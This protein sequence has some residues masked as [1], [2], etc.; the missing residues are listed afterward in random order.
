MRNVI[1]SS[2]T[3]TAQKPTVSVDHIDNYYIVEATGTQPAVAD[4]RWQYVAPGGA[5]PMPT[6]AAPYLWHKTVTVLTDGSTLDPVVEFAGSMGQNGIDYDLVP[7]HSSILKGEDNSLTPENVTCALVKRN[8]DGSA[9]NQTTVPT[10][11]SIK[12]T[13]DTTTTTYTLGAIV[14]TSGVSLIVFS[15]YYGTV[16]IERHTISVVAEGGQGVDGRGI[17]SQDYRFKAES[18]GTQP[19]APTTDAQWNTWSALNAAGYSESVP[20]LWR[21]CK[22]VYVDGHGNTETVYVV[23]GP[24]VWGHNGEDIFYLDLDNEMDSI[25][26]DSTGTTLVQVV[27]TTNY[28]L[29]KG[30]GN[31]TSQSTAPTAAN[32]RLAGITPTVTPGS[33]Y[34]RLQWTIP[35]NTT[36]SA[37]KYAVTV[38]VS[39]DGS[40]YRAVFTANV[41]KSGEPGVSPAIYQLLLSATEASFARDGSNVLTPTQVQV[42]CGYT[43]SVG[44]TI[45]K[46]VGDS[47]SD[48]MSIDSKYNIFYRPI[49]ANGKAG[50]WAWMKDL[51]STNFYLN[52]PSSTRN[53]AYEFVLSSSGIYTLVADS[54]IVDRETLPINKDGLNGTQGESAFVI[55][56][57]NDTDAF[58][59]DCDGKISASIVRETTATMYYGVTPLDLT[60]LSYT[61]KYEDGTTC[62]SEVAVATD[63]STGKVTV[64]LGST[65]YA[66]TKTIFIDITGSCS[67]GSKTIRFTIQPQAGGEPGVSPIIYQLMPVPSVLSFARNDS[68]SLIIANNVITGYVKKVEGN[69]P[70]ILSSLSGYRIYYGYGNPAT[71][72]SYIAVGGTITVNA[73]NAA[74]Y[75]QLVLELW[76][77][78]GTTK[79]KRLDRETIPI[80]KDGAKG[81]QGNDGETP[82][83]VDIDNEMTSIP[84]STEGKVESQ[85]VLSFKLSAWYGQTNV[86]NDVD[87][88]NNAKCTVALVGTAPSGFTV[89]VTTSKSNPRITIAANTEPA[90]I[91]ELT[92]RVTHSDY[93]SRDAVFSIAA[94]KSGDKGQDAVLYELLPSDSQIAV[95]RTD[96]GGYDPSTATLTCGYIKKAG[97]ATPTTV[98]DATGA[99]DGYSIYFRRYSRTS[100]WGYFYNYVTYKSMLSG[101]SV[102]TYSK[103][104][105]ILCKNTAAYFANESGIT[106]LIDKEAV[107]IVADGQKG[108]DGE[109]AFVL[110]IDNEMAAIPV[111][112]TGKVVTQKQL[113]FG[114]AAYYGA[115]PVLSACAVSYGTMTNGSFSEN[116]LPTGFSVSVNDPANPIVTINA[117]TTPAEITEVTFRAV[118]T[119]YG[120]RYATFTVCAVKS[121][122]KG[123]DA[124]IYQLFPGYSSLP[125]DRDSS[126]NLNTRSYTLTCQIQKIIGS[127]VTNHDSLSGYYMYYGWDGETS[128][129]QNWAGFV[130]VNQTTAA[131]HTSVVIELWRGTRSTGTRLDRETIPIL[132]DGSVG[133]EGGEGNGIGSVSKHRMFTLN[134][135][136]PSSG[137]SGWIASS[138]GSYPSTEGLSSENKY[139]WE[140]KVTT[141]TKASVS[142]TTDIYLVAQFE[143]GVHENL[144]ED[145]AFLSEGEMEAWETKNGSISKN[146]VGNHNGFYGTP[147]WENQNTELLQQQLYYYGTLQK[148]KANTWYTLSFYA[149]MTAY[150]DLLTSSVYNGFD[151]G[152]Y[153]QIGA[154][155]K[156]FWLEAGQSAIV[157]VTGRCYSSSVFLRI[158]GYADGWVSGLTSSVEFTSTSSTT[159]SFLVTNSGSVARLFYV[160]G[161]V[162][163][164][165]GNETHNSATDLNH[166][167]YITL[168]RV[169][170]GAMLTSYI[171][172]SDNGQAVQHSSSAPW[173]VNG[174]KITAWTQLD[175]HPN[176]GRYVT[177]ANGNT[178]NV[179]TGTRVGFSDDGAIYWQLAPGTRKL[180]FTFKTPSSLATGVY[181]RV[182]F[183]M[184]ERSHDGWVSMP[185][186]EENTCATDWIENTNDRKADDIQHVYVGDWTSGTTYFYG[187][188]T[189]V[190]HVVRAKESASGSYIYFRMKLRTTSAGYTS[191]IQPYN[192]T[193]HWEAANYLKFTASE[194]MLAEEVITDKLTV[195]K[196]RTQGADSYIDVHDGIIDFFG[197]LGF[198]NITLGVD[199]NGCAVLKFYDKDGNFKYDLGPD[200]ISQQ[201]NNVDGSFVS[202]GKLGAFGDYNSNY[203]LA[204]VRS[205]TT[206]ETSYYYKFLE[207]YTNINS[208][209]T[210]D[211]SGNY[212][213]KVYNGNTM[214]SQNNH[215]RPGT[216]L[217]LITQGYYV[218]AEVSH[219]AGVNIYSRA[220]Y[221]V[222][223]SGASPSLLGR[224]YYYKGNT[225]NDR[226]LTDA[227]GN[228]LSCST[229]QMMSYYIQSQAER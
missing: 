194:L 124:E 207:G 71:P 170:R 150:H 57:D 80:N 28:R 114:L 107:P 34:V 79:E 203:S 209:K 163:L 166:R 206:I 102:A 195:T 225:I 78:N 97:T 156:G 40:T 211:F 39:N 72:T 3:L 229:S 198:P 12:V 70:T 177:L 181:Y 109:N 159:K 176:G 56:L 68:G 153:W 86:I 213:N 127:V 75:T 154:S 96:A 197:S 87:T 171:Y 33:D 7:S 23:D 119:L 84:I 133:P 19:A 137:D 140:K 202:V 147:V 104:Q 20:Y 85:I 58:G 92:F 112:S 145:T 167:C 38:P 100:G 36:L 101:F 59:T 29:Y 21:C 90:E 46:H 125:F 199:S 24:T 173:Y 208:V 50:T 161:Y 74:S 188:G 175:D 65:S 158:F 82:F 178:A 189:G 169:D 168:I 10:G 41:V 69:E 205:M 51:T 120:T 95:G 136:E 186:L 184:A 152:S 17:Q 193:Q 162:Y 219:S 149:A 135:V 26:C 126:G 182:L 108:S 44:T 116:S 146:V 25:P 60:G 157:T 200:G 27:L 215:L 47:Q 45:E 35:A 66:Y 110:D 32:I 164:T 73:T 15:L 64:T 121:G 131:S 117:N 113:T 226:Y 42:R 106:G 217:A 227:N 93:G 191:S 94:V 160:E 22:T 2:F 132:R 11:Y 220:V 148:L 174:K 89:D 201:L 196:M 221:Y 13:R 134:F 67:R 155:K 18:T 55:D 123:E 1:S 183:R 179:Q 210:Y 105:F 8:A 139:L 228:Q 91:T 172:R 187:G 111:D 129:T 212:N 16:E 81:E 138:S 218:G 63:T 128:P 62:G 118:H 99:V 190:R 9:D 14:P 83:I 76:K 142:A 115:S 5:I 192:D 214:T 31:I 4:S 141:Y 122:G 61:K 88:N 185:K 30:P 223:S 222:E 54:N 151:G 180:T 144:L 103:V 37:E 48:L 6:A 53:V 52:I 77:M 143:D 43:K 98:T 49:L 204:R 224:Y 216:S 130:T 165:D